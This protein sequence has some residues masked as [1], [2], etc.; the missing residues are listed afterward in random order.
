V[1][2]FDFAARASAGGADRDP[3]RVVAEIM[4]DGHFGQKLDRLAAD[5]GR[6]R[7]QVEKEA[8]AA[9]HEMVAVQSDL[10][11]GAIDRLAR[12]ALRAY[13]IE[14]DADALDS[15][16]ALNR[17][18]GLV[19]L[20]SHK[21]YLDPFILRGALGG[22]GL[23]CNHVLG[24]VNVSFWPM[25]PILRR[26]GIVFIRRSI[27]DD[28]VYKAALRFY[29]GYLVERRYNLEWY[30]EGGRS[31]TGKL[32]PPRLGVLSY[33]VEAYRERGVD[34][35][36]L[37]PVSIAYDQLQEVAAMAAEE[38]GAEKK[39]ESLAW[40]LKYIRSQGQRL[41]KAYINFAEPVSLRQVR[42]V[43][44][45][46]TEKIAFE[47]LH[48]IN[49]VTPVTP[50]SLLTLALLGLGDRAL[51][52]ADIRSVLD[53][54]LDYVAVR[55]L[56]QA[57]TADL[58]TAAGVQKALDG[59][60]STKVVSRYTG[61]AEPVYRIGEDQHLVAAYFRNRIIHFFVTRAITELVLLH[62]IHPPVGHPGPLGTRGV[63]PTAPA[64]AAQGGDLGAL[65]WA[66]A[67]RLRDLFKYE[68][69]F[70][71]KPEF[72]E[73]LRAELAILDPDWER[74]AGQ[75]HEG[76]Q[77]QNAIVTG[78]SELPL[79][80]G[81]RVLGSFIEAYMV[82]ADRLAGCPSGPVDEKAFLDQCVGVA[83]QYRLQ[84]RIHSGE[85]I[86]KELFRN[87]LSLARGRGLLAD[88][89]DPE[90]AT[91]ITG[92]RERFAAEIRDVVDRIDTLRRLAVAS[93]ERST[94]E[95]PA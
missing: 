2:D 33:L 44:K 69:F 13:D 21:S 73:E 49:R 92:G 8:R 34:D 88:A 56:P 71:A 67:L 4:A 58:T 1:A 39:A 81:H 70:A 25:G 27:K 40:M 30:L 76:L 85:S 54:L 86:S 84:H 55:K 46:A 26:S 37:V 5:H 15:L 95:A 43:R 16:R 90:T 6:S 80:L 22:A 19:F 3:D 29:L 32:R 52:P 66:E 87:G 51:T 82:V 28:P 35:V 77:G 60:V 93:L 61:G 36:F 78:L 45:L 23:P 17:S 31:R 41:G 10:A 7:T 57:G 68:F 53:P 94:G 91:E 24:G 74:K 20:P 12:F 14:A 83:K 59:L 47:V 64:G 65:A 89:R 42:T 18:H 62:L 11:L 38:H 9:L 79:L 50:T 75:L 72:A 48:R 63:A